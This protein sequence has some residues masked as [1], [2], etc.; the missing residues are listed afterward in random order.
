MV[1]LLLL[2]FLKRN[3]ERYES[4]MGN[5][6]RPVALVLAALYAVWQVFVQPVWNL[7]IERLAEKEKID[8]TL[9]NWD[10]LMDTLWAI[11]AYVPKSFPLGFVVGALIFA[12]WDAII[13]A[14]RK[15]I[16]RKP[17][18]PI[19]GGS[20][21]RAWLGRMVP[22]FEE[23]DSILLMLWVINLGTVPFRFGVVS[24]DIK[25]TYV[26]GDSTRRYVKLSVLLKE[27]CTTGSPL[28][29]G[30]YGPLWLHVP[31]PK[32]LRRELPDTF[33]WTP[34]PSLSFENLDIQL[35]S[36]DG[37]HSKSLELWDSM[38]LSAGEN[39]I[40]YDETMKL[41]KSDEERKD[42]AEGLAKAAA[43]LKKIAKD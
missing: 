5:K 3:E 1:T 22:F 31:I 23:D 26:A 33:G 19:E 28:E 8:T 20:P 38:R 9:S 34:Y 2:P 18:A 11:G 16:L 25:F 29:P 12:Y 15:Y 39:V 24:G 32:G 35:V 21:L 17:D 14:V 6:K 13:A 40:R 27:S 7:N 4:Y 41:F 43:L 10:R 30:Y 42:V 36:E 37:L